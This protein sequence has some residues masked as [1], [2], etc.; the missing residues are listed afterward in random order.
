[1]EEAEG[2]ELGSAGAD[3]AGASGVDPI[4]VALVLAGAS[5]EDANAFL[6]DQRS[7]IADQKNLVRLQAK[8]LAHE[9]RLRHWS[10]QLRHAS[11]ILKFLLEISAA[12]I[13]VGLAC[14]IGAVVWNAAHADGLVI[15][16]FSVPPD[17]AAR[18]LTGQAIAGLLTDKLS[19]LQTA[20]DS[21]RA[22]RS[23]SND[24]GDNIKV[25][26]ADTG[27]SVGEAYR[28][29]KRWLGHETHVSGD[30]WRTQNGV[31]IAARVDGAGGT[32]TGAEADVDGVIQKVAEDIYGRTQPYRYA[33]YLSKT[34]RTDESI[35][36][37]KTLAATGDPADR[38]W[39]YVGLGVEQMDTA[40]PAQVEQLFRRAEAYGMAIGA[41]NLATTELNLGRW[42]SA[43]AEF[44]KAGTLLRSG[45]GGIDPGQ[46]SLF[47]QRTAGIQA[48]MLGDF[49]SAAQQYTASVEG[50]VRTVA[51]PS[52]ELAQFQSLDHDVAAARES[53]AHPAVRRTVY[54]ADAE[55][56]AHLD[57]ARV[58]A[59]ETQDWKAVLAGAHSM[60]PMF[61]KDPGLAALKVTRADPPTAI[62]QAHLG[63][64]ADAERLVS[65]MPG[66][67]Y[68]C[69]IGRAKVAAL[70]GNPA[71]ADWWFDRAASADPSLPLAYAEWGEALLA[72]GAPDAA[73]ERFKLSTQKGPHFADPLEMWGEALM[74]KNQ[75][76]LALAKFA[77]AD[78]YAP[79]WGRLHL[80]WGEALMYTGKN[81]EARAQYQK[82][83]TLDL[84][85]A[86]K[87]ELARQM[88]T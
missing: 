10:L 87:A 48:A 8:E 40:A 4:A 74:A 20:T 2:L 19:D 15:E 54:A 46:V 7:L 79:N 56:L 33:V 16:S 66:D 76:H 32:S 1:V 61:Q 55:T 22:A 14:F 47:L 26:I 29:L 69:L 75:S 49:H 70:E 38:G 64:F 51:N 68:L 50:G 84:T 44:T 24:W 27:V 63:R 86:D 25:E 21:N 42:E 59:Q 31:T 6:R 17:L 53:L 72:R 3:A 52:D 88:R 11:A 67:C 81:D 9:L 60:E 12:L 30:V 77:E 35:A 82:A 58:L 36:R 62:A 73:I 5:R 57:A 23:Y 37:L 28:F 43:M 39:A 85:A 65:G 71:R 34:G 41:G 13:A 45:G 83:S 80:K 78:K 18:G